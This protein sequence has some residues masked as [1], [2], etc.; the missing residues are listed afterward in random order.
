MNR[1]EN[2]ESQLTNKVIVSIITPLYNCQ[3]VI[4]E[5]I[6]SVLAQTYP[7]W[8]LIIVDDVSSD[9]SREIVKEYEALDKRIK[10]IELSVNGE[11]L[12]PVIKELKWH[13]AVLLLF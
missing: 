12:L 10:L 9:N 3:D 4:R 11:L 6:D 2:I 7:H 8:E 5:T 13:K 1:M